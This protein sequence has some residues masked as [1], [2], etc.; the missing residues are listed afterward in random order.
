MS[1][2]S[3]S[4]YVILECCA[5]RGAVL[6]YTWFYYMVITLVSLCLGYKGATVFPDVSSRNSSF[7]INDI[8][9]FAC[10]LNIQI[11]C[12]KQKLKNSKFLVTWWLTWRF[13]FPDIYLPVVEVGTYSSC[14]L[15][16]LEQEGSSQSQSTC[17]ILSAPSYQ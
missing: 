15:A 6:C 3:F 8:L 1:N 14:Q 4:H 16:V 5:T 11:A 10:Q 2:S 13:S 7:R 9:Q 17:H 12:C